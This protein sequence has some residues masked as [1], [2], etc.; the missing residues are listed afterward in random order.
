VAFYD[1]LLDTGLT[2]NKSLTLGRLNIPGKFFADF[3]RG[4]FDGDG[5]IYGVID[6]R[7]KN[8]YMYYIT[9]SSASRGFTNWLAES[10]K[11]QL[12]QTGGCVRAGNGNVLQLAFAKRDSKALFK[13]MYYA[14][15]LPYLDR[16]YARFLEVFARDPYP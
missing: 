8:S 6:K 13:F 4:C 16:K 3:L 2:P 1:F 11:Q 14:D 15:G 10:I 7:W 9:F 5:C 12:P